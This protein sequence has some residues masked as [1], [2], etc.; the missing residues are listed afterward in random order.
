MPGRIVLSTT[1]SGA[2][3][4]TERMRIGSAGDIVI[5]QPAGRYTLDTTPGQ[6]TVANNGTVDFAN[7]SGVLF[8]NN[9]NNGAVTMWFMGGG[10][11]TAMSSIIAT[12]GS[13]A[14]VP[15][16]N[17]YRWTNNFGSAATLG[18]MF[19]RTRPNA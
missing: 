7:S 16:I 3:S 14:H 15:G 9:Y 6:V 11:V 1:A 10:T 8:V 5:S 12:V 17:G 4:P 18:F 2:S 19:F 13:M